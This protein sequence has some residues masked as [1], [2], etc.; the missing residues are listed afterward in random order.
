MGR[1]AQT[2]GLTYSK[3]CPAIVRE[4][5]ATEARCSCRMA[6]CQKKT[7][8][9][10]HVKPQATNWRARWRQKESGTEKLCAHPPTTG[11]QLLVQLPQLPHESHSSSWLALRAGVLRRAVSPPARPR[12]RYATSSVSVGRSEFAPPQRASTTK[13]FGRFNENSSYLVVIRRQAAK[14]VWPNRSLNRTLCSGPGLGFKSLAQT[15]PAANCRLA[16]TTRAS[17]P[18][19]PNRSRINRVSD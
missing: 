12:L 5:K 18:V 19:K 11:K 8:L 15:Q 13:C 17:P 2:L 4:N 6:S 1:L 9:H 3:P 14:A 7:A 10:R 16:Q